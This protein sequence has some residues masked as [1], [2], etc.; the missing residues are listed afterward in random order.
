[1]KKNFFILKQIGQ[2]TK[3]CQEIIE[4]IKQIFSLPYIDFGLYKI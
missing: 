1:M 4:L 2:K 3:T